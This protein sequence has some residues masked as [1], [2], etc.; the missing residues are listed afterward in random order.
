VAHLL[1]GFGRFDVF[2]PKGPGSAL[3][4]AGRINRAPSLF[5]PEYAVAARFLD[6]AVASTNAAHELPG[7]LFDFFAAKIG[8]P[9]DFFG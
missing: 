8:D 4:W 1:P 5:I 9:P 2:R 7:K 6:E 3:R